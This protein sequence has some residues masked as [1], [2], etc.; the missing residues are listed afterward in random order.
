LI[1]AHGKRSWIIA[2]FLTLV[3]V[4][5]AGHTA[6]LPSISPEDAKNIM[7]V[8]EIRRGM[9]GYGLTVFHGTKVEKFDLEVLGVL[10]QMN[11][12]GDL[13]M[14]RIGGGP[15]T[16]RNTG[17]IAGMSGSPCY[18]NGK[19]IGAIAYG[20][21]YAKEPIGM[22]TPI[23]D[24]L[25]AWDEHLPSQPSG[26]S[27]P[28]VDLPQPISIGGKTVHKIVIGKPGDDSAEISDGVLRMVPLMT[29]VMV[30]GLSPRGIGR[31]A[32]MLRGYGVM[33]MAG[34]GSKGKE[35]VNA[36]LSPGSAVGMSLA[37]GDIDITAIGTLTYRRGNKIVAFGHPMLGIGAIDAPL[38]TAFVDDLISSYRVSFK[39][40]SPLKT[41]GRVFQDRPWSIAGAVGVAPKTIPATISIADQAFKR[42]KTYRV[43]VINH[44]LLA[45]TLLTLV[46][47]EAIYEM[48][49][50][51]GDATA[52]VEYE[53]VADEVGTIKRSNV[54]F[55]ETSV[56][57][58]AMSDLG[59]LLRLLSSN[60]F[61]PLDVKSVNVK[62]RIIAKRSTAVIDKI[63]VKERE[64]EPGETVEV[65]VV[66]R[67]Y[68]QPRVTKTFPI[69]IPATAPDGKLNLV[70]R[71]GSSPARGLTIVSIS[72]G[73]APTPIVQPDSG[74]ELANADNVKQLVQKYLEREKNNEIVIQLFT[75][76]TTVNVAGEKLTGLP[77]V[78][79]DVM[80][81]SRS[82]GI[83]LER[84]EVKKI[85]PVDMIVSGSAQ[86]SLDVKR[87]AIDESQPGS[88]PSPPTSG[89]DSDSQP[90]PSAATVDYGLLDDA[91][92][93]ATHL[94]LPE[95]D[96]Q[97]RQTEVKPEQPKVN[98]EEKSAEESAP[99]VQKPAIKEEKASKE[100][101]SSGTEVKTVVRQP[102]V[103]IQR[104]QA[105]FAKGNSRGVAVS[106]DGSL[107]LVP[108]VRKLVE[109]PEQFVWCLVPT[110]D[111]GVYVGTGD[112]GRVYRVSNSGNI[113]LFY[114]TG[115]LE[116]HALARDSK[117]NLF[118][119]TSPNGRVFRV[120]PDGKGQLCFQAD[121]KYV[122][123]L[124]IDNDDNVYVALGDSGRIYR[125]T[126]QG[127]TSVF[128]ELPEQQ[129]LSLCWSSQGWLAA[130]T[131][132]NGIAYRIDQAGRTI[133]VFDAQEES[134]TAMTVDKQGNLYL[135]TSPRGGI[136]KIYP[137]GQSSC[138]LS[139]VPQVF[140]MT[141]VS[142]GEVYAACGEWLVRV[143]ND[144]KVVKFNSEED[145]KQYLCVVYEPSSN[146]LFAGTSDVATV[147]LAHCNVQEGWYESCVHDTRGISRWS[148]IKWGA[149]V[150][151]GT[152][153]ALQTRTGNASTPDSTWSDWSDAYADSNG[154]Q[155]LSPPG[156]FIQYRVTMKT[157]KPG[158]T[159][160]VS[161]VSISYLPPNG[162][163]KLSLVTP[164]GGEVWGGKKTIRWSGSDP[165]N[166]T[167]VY[168]VYYSSDG[169]NW[170]TLVGGLGAEKNG[171][172]GSSS[173]AKTDEEITSKV[174]S[175]L[176][177][178]KDVPEEMK[179]EV[180]KDMPSL[181]KA[182]AP[183]QS[184]SRAEAP[185]TSTSYTWD[186]TKVN[187]GRYIIKVVASDRP[188]NGTDALTEEVVSDPVTICNT[189][190]KLTL[191]TKALDLTQGERVE[192]AGSASSA[193][194]EI[195]GVQCRVDG[196]TWIAASAADGIFD[197]LYEPFTF[198]LDSLA[199]G[200]HKIE[201][202]AI[203]A[204][205][206]ASTGVIEVRVADVK[207]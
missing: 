21:G 140:S 32:E 122:L 193:L 70:V 146:T 185:T 169:T 99:T 4:S 173:V 141:C 61:Y 119:G 94:M 12:G 205:G 178:S 151:D 80:K 66:L 156:R 107:V 90:N 207:K 58:V 86:L 14:V 45:S 143:S 106:S 125:I 59:S 183:T 139:N 195:V 37:R 49:P 98:V 164:V 50:V 171:S 53:V 198:A 189:P 137:D 108:Q 31:L 129:V 27:S 9:R 118:I 201:V 191:Y 41:V 134:V 161:F 15:I 97:Q 132:T 19:L 54:F 6:S 117:G 3:F 179:K 111:G 5:V 148:K 199:I 79:A 22:V 52:E 55:D 162:K 77:S 200:S 206:N 165:D 127:E 23:A 63:F 16:K 138:L 101:T 124:A 144:E 69:K 33:P 85:F 135:G 72:E 175:E 89:T 177:K 145:K 26:H 196:G 29:P 11:N 158:S 68:K 40:A 186:T 109:T 38:T 18:I 116:V 204:A 46:V 130:G 39:V 28:P 157:A 64:Y 166:D 133:P 56:D 142:S 155:I 96:Y 42:S 104:T 167:L 172:Q 168:D 126:P 202:Q 25:E 82:S 83:R 88:K 57:T 194:A 30:S 65:G 47:G 121:G 10:K 113:E 44:P 93:Y 159:P 188:S 131:G 182:A 190:P 62:V 115:E 192:F 24:M 36:E 74:S 2:T 100:Q 184:A 174:R 20:S 187:D 76:N 91:D 60:R 170:Q 87:K 147:Y 105:D 95:L 67:P 197:S 103:W 1:R 48:H 180:L 154:T 43:Q 163:P 35:A 92:E 110:G 17:I 114:E 152:S 75:R 203:D 149:Q 51:P 7:P 128:A 112:S 84:E 73:G 120:A 8:S 123:A 13:I 136:Y 153:V 176:E 34:P 160:K 78:I 71:G 181:P 102:K 150:S 81:S